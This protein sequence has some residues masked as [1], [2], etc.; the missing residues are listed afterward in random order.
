MMTE[1][2]K[3][4]CQEELERQYNARASV[5]DF[6]F[7]INRYQS[8]SAKS[9]SECKVVQDL[10]YGLTPSE[11]IDYFPTVKD[12]PVFIFIHGGYWRL[13]GRKDSAFMAKALGKIGISTAVIEYT[14]APE[15]TLDQIVDEIRRAVVWI[16]NNIKYHGGDPARLFICG[17]SAGAQLSA[18]AMT[19]DW[20]TEHSLPMNILKGGLLLSGLYDL[21]PVRHC[22]PNQWLQLDFKAAKRNSPQHLNFAPGPNLHISWGE[23]ET[24]EFKRQSEEFLAK[25]QKSGIHVTGSE[26]QNRN[27]FDIVTD[28]ADP[29]SELF[30]IVGSM[31]L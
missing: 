14:L 20:L 7:E 22:I 27:H 5:A 6:D 28:L 17:S 8:L 25:L 11:R 10:S 13:L 24:D 2:W 31:M 29:H 16:F 18:M 19:R 4:F 1:I 30:K 23:K 21:E 12:A 9:Y 3:S 15:A 26:T